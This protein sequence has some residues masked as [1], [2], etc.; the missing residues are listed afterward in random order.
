MKAAG[1]VPKKRVKKPLSK[2]TKLF[3]KIFISALL[4]TAVSF[5]TADYLI[6][7]RNKKPPVFSIKV[8]EY[9]NGSADYYG[10]FYKVWEDYDPFDDE[11]EYFLTFWL[12]PKFWSI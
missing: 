3:L 5:F 4:L 1:Y 2:R 8:Y 7:K 6:V 12:F 10:L 9:D 11:T